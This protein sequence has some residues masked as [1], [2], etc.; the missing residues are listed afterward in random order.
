M[1]ICVKNEDLGVLRTL[2]HS[3]FYMAD[4]MDEED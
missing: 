2:L 1:H 4:Q 3:K